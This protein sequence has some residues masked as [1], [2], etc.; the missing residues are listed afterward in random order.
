MGQGEASLMD[1]ARALLDTD[2]NVVGTAYDPTGKT[3]KE[4]EADIAQTRAEMSEALDALHAKLAPQQLLVLGIEGL[5]RRTRRGVEHASPG[6]GIGVLLPAVLIGAGVFLLTKSRPRLSD[7]EDRTSSRSFH[8]PAHPDQ[9]DFRNVRRHL[10]RLSD[11]GGHLGDGGEVR[12]S[13][14]RGVAG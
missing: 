3:S 10:D 8:G 14:A 7:D 5:Q 13:G 12:E 4:I 11:V 9:T 2:E 1:N 6:A